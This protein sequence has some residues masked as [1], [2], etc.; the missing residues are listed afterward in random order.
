MAGLAAGVNVRQGSGDPRGDG[1]GITIRGISTLSSTAVLVI[2]D[3]VNSY[4]SN[5]GTS[6]I[7]GI[8][9]DDIESIS[10]LKDAASA[11]IYGALAANGVILITTKKGSKKKPTMTYNGLFSSARASGLPHWVSNSVQYMNL[12]NEAYTN[13]GS[14]VVFTDATIQQFTTAQQHP[15]DTTAGGIPNYVAYP[16]TDWAKALIKKSVVQ[17]HNISVNGGN[18]NTTY[19]FSLGYLKNPG[20][21][22]NSGIEAYRF[23]INV[24]SKIGSRITVGTQTYGSYQKDGLANT[25]NLFNYMPQVSPMVYPVY[26]GQY[27]TSSA[28]GDAVQSSQ[29]LVGYLNSSF[30]SDVYTN[31]STTWYGKAELLKGLTFEP[32][33]NYQTNI[34]ETN[35][36]SNANAAVRWNW[37]GTA[38]TN[39]Q[40]FQTSPVTPASALGT[41]SAWYKSY[42]Y[43]LES[44]LRYNTAIAKDHNIGAL[45]GFS[46]YYTNYYYTS[47]SATG[48][49]D[50]AVPAIGTATIPGKPS[51]SAT[52]YSFRSVF[53]RLTYNYQEKYLFEGNFRRDASSRF[54]PDFRYGVF[55]S[56]AVGWNLTRE[57]FLQSLRDH[58]IQ[59]LKL[60]ASWG[61]LGNTAPGN[62]SWQASYG[63]V[64]Y[65]FNNVVVNGIRLGAIANPVLH[66]ETT[67]VT[68]IGMDLLALKKLNVTFDWYSRYTTGILFTPPLD[69]TVGAASAP[70]VNLAK[71]INQGMELTAGWNDNIGKVKYNINANFAYNYHNAVTQYKGPLVAG[72]DSSHTNYNS[73]IGA[74]SAG[75]TNRVL[76]GHM[77]N[78]FYVQTVYHGDGSYKAGGTA[79]V[80]NGPKTGM[81]RTPDDYQW[82]LAM[83]ANGYKFAQGN[84]NTSLP[85][86]GTGKTAGLYY[87]DLIYADNN[88]DKTFGNAN[89]AK[90]MKISTIPKYVFGLNMSTS[91][92]NFT[93]S[94]VWAGA[95]G[96]K[97]YWNQG[98]YNSITMA[99]QGNISEKIANN[100][101]TTMAPMILKTISTVSIPVLNPVMP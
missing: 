64:P 91:W 48:L 66:W 100:H 97:T 83:Y 96:F 99:L 88:G 25:G 6:G 11:A 36:W 95:A 21:V 31:L 37:A 3:G 77:I 18:E 58:N 27:A 17:N 20:L 76:E 81:I 39:Y 52:D 12:I 32:R 4:N 19:N 63:A 16:N 46:Q 23:R 10:V 53:G 51:G 28:L 92:N 54:G 33:V 89:D 65:S 29:G 34:E 87:G 2:I 82:V 93:F 90:F 70:T 30:G 74:V 62:Y 59:N 8:N 56:F 44:L 71:A 42:S 43:T 57:D 55:P 80:T 45:L 79:T 68:N 1:A 47:V 73:N 60:R 24:E 40:P 22:D 61:Q 78:E 94:M 15:N 67:N 98:Y 72:W 85:A 50:Q 49:L 13:I 38:A 26:K 69:I 7:D 14:P 86:D 35:T 75:G 84:P 9:P 101:Y 41:G 5:A